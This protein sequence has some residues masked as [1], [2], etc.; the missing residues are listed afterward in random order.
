MKIAVTRLT[1]A[2]LGSAIAVPALAEE[3][4]VVHWLTAGAESAAIQVLVDGVEARGTTWIDLATPGGGSDARA[5]FS[6]RLAGG[7]PVGAL[8]MSIGPEAIE[9]GEQGVVRDVEGFAQEN[10]LIASVPDFA[11]DIARGSDGELF[12]LPV[13]LETQNF[14]WYSLPAFEAA[15]IEPATTWQGLID[16]APALK[17]AGIIPLAMGAQG[18]QIDILFTAVIASVAGPEKYLAIYRDRDADAAAS[19]DVLE[20]FRIM[21]ALSELQDEG[22]SNRAWNDTL[23]LVAQDKA[24]VQVMGSW[25]GAELASMGETYGTDWGCALAGGGGAI[26]GSTGFAFPV[27]SENEGGQND[28][29]LTLMDPAVQTAFSVQKGSIPARTDAST[30]GLSECAVVAAESVAAGNG[31]PN[32]SAVLNPDSRGQINDM[33]ANFWSNPSMSPEDAAKTFASLIGG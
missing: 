6:S 1:A 14:M 8:F 30:E 26:V 23:N 20:A 11:L 24:A 27:L 33:M 4:E 3:V 25:A 18:W 2:L 15:G 17:E 13:A 22:S 10:D 29:I 19:D 5:L 21:R 12:A 16:A 31:M 28:F 32:V 9:L 7:D